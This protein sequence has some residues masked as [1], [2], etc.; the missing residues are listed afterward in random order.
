MIRMLRF[1]Y[2]EEGDFLIMGIQGEVRV[3]N[4]LHLKKELEP[5]MREGGHIAI[6]MEHVKMIDS[7]GISLL[8]NLYKKLVPQERRLC[9]FGM[10]PAVDRVFRETN[11]EQFLK[12]YPTHEEFIADNTEEVLDELYPPADYDFGDRMYLLK[13]LKCVLCDSE[14]I[15]GFVLNRRTQEICFDAGNLTPSFRGREGNNTLDLY[16]MQ[17]TICG[18][19]F[20]ASRHINYFTDLKGEFQSLLLE[21]EIHTL[22][23]EDSARAR[24]LKGSGMNSADMFYPPYSSKECYW[25]YAMAEECAHILYRLDNRLATYD[26][27]YYNTLLTRYCGDKELPGF[28]RK[29]YMWYG[30]IFKN[31]DHFA[32]VTVMEACYY[33]AVISVKLKREKESEFYY[34]NLQ[35]MV[36]PN[37]EYKVYL[38][39]AAQYFNT[40]K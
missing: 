37:P 2:T 13:N 6:D 36:L 31:P 14:N 21:K 15:K 17:V 24:M 22:V 29:A 1:T 9:L 30:E 25:V 20:F 23:K 28:L 35:K 8:I 19:C 7:S 16:A 40:G 5:L 33:L 3:S 10:N 32:S 12:T 11:L 18:N 34:A 26:L 27:A 4:I 39:A 38:R